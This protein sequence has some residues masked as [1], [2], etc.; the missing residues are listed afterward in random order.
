MRFR[1]NF[2]IVLSSIVLTAC[3]GGS[4]GAPGTTTDTLPDGFSGV[5]SDSG[6]ITLAITDGPMEEAEELVLH[7]THIDFGH[8]NGDVTRVP[9]HGGPTDLDMMQLQNGVTR[10]LIDNARLPAGRYHWVEI[11]V[12]LGRSHIGLQGGGHHGMELA[13]PEAMRVHREFE[14]HGGHHDE[15]VVDFDLRH[16]VR[17]H[18]GGGGMGNRY[19]LHHGLRLM[20]ADNAG[21][22]MGAIDDSLVDI[23]HPDCDPAPGGNWAYLFPGD[24]AQPDDLAVTDVDGFAG[25]LATDRV[26]LH[27]G[28]GEYRY[29]F[30]FLPADTYRV[31]FSCSSE[32]DEPGDDDYPMDPD[33]AFDFQTFSDPIEV[34][35]GQM[36]VVDIVP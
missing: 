36:T 24:A 4:G 10:H 29:H 22:L 26:E 9:L 6:T 33:G 3:G 30:A 32:W 28:L 16:G 12:D 8:E 18:H 27:H 35:A 25:P 14:I 2:L 11:G 1:C 19:E 23:N 34:V 31:A 13:D 20:H 5:P 15:F 7:L 21:G 17:H